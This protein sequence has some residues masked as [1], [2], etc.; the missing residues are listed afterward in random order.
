MSS[1]S[2]VTVRADSPEPPA[3][4]QKTFAYRPDIVFLQAFDTETRVYNTVAHVSTIKYLESLGMTAP[5]LRRAM[6]KH[7]DG[8]EIKQVRLMHHKTVVEFFAHW[9]N[10]HNVEAAFEI[11]QPRDTTWP[12]SACSVFRLWHE[13][14]SQDDLHDS[15]FDCVIERLKSRKQQSWSAR[16]L[17]K[18]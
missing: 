4:R 13:D 18:A 9:I 3:K 12:V 2:S 15:V 6:T 8:V 10:E 7:V 16:Y 14:V 11:C 5:D 17:I 1:D